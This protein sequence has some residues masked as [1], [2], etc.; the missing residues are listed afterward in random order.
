MSKICNQDTLKQIY[1]ALIHSHISYGI[2]VYGA[3]TKINLDKI[4]KVQK[5]AIRVILN[6]KWNE[7]VKHLFSELQILTIYNLYIL[8]TVVFTHNNN[9]AQAT[10]SHNY[11]T[12]NK[13]VLEGLRII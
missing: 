10:L 9:Y 11:D 6:L 12:R 13:L 3:T 5:K 7:S 4:L 1:F 2:S 8:E